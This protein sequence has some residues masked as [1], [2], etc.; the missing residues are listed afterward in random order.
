[1][2]R[3]GCPSGASLQIRCVDVRFIGLGEQGL[4]F[5][6]RI[7]QAGWQLSA[8][9]RRAAV[10]GFAEELAAQSDLIGICVA[11][12]DDVLQVV[13]SLRGGLGQARLSPST[14]PSYPRRAGGYRKRWGRLRR[15]S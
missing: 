9:A 8:W 11:T 3:S 4:P 13:D 2:G 10:V 7:L 5:A 6:E 15:R 14:A 1:M 12:D